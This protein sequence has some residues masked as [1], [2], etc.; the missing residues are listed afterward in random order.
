M[1]SEHKVPMPFPF[2]HKKTIYINWLAEWHSR[3][4][5]DPIV[6]KRY[7]DERASLTLFEEMEAGRAKLLWIRR[8]Q[9][10]DGERTTSNCKGFGY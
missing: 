7:F 3:C 1:I 8:G 5:R 2:L 9:E 6:K 10:Y 4:D